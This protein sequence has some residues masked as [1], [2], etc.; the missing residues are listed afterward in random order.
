VAK[1]IQYAL[2]CS[3]RCNDRNSFFFAWCVLSIVCFAVQFPTFV[4]RRFATSVLRYHAASVAPQWT[5]LTITI[6]PSADQKMCSATVA[7]SIREI[8][9]AV[10]MIDGGGIVLV[11]GM[12]QGRRLIL[13]GRLQ[14]AVEMML[15]LAVMHISVT[16]I[17]SCQ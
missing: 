2:M 8:S 11:I 7:L 9:T 4:L 16:T 10:W 12:G 1:Y 5:S 13:G 14:M 6:V 15:V 3:T 17:A